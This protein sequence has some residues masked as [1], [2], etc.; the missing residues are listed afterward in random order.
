MT[1]VAETSTVDWSDYDQCPN[2]AARRGKPC[3]N[4]HTGEVYDNTSLSHPRQ[5][6][7]EVK[8][9]RRRFDRYL[10]S[11]VDQVAAGLAQVGVNATVTFSADKNWYVVRY[12]RYEATLPI[13]ICEVDG[14]GYQ[15]CSALRAGWGN[16]EGVISMPTDH[17]KKKGVDHVPHCHNWHAGK[18]VEFC[19]RLETLTSK[20]NR[21]KPVYEVPDT[22]APLLG[23]ETILFDLEAWS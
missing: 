3:K 13:C 4:V 11:T 23:E 5:T 2:C 10:L 8:A 7:A 19:K 21:P 12:G 14:L 20:E 6:V 1:A 9:W 15:L 22:I 16:G 18:L 17:G